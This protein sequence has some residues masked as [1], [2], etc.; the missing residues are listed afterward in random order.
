MSRRL[1]VLV[2]GG[3]GLIGA[4]V[5]RAFLLHGHDVTVLSRG[6][7]PVAAGATPLV[8]DR[9]DPVS[10]AGVLAGRRYDFVADLLAYD[11]ADVARLL[12]VPGFRCPRYALVS[13]GQ[14]YLVSEQRRPPFREGDAALPVAPE[15]EAGT[16]DHGNWLYGVGKREAERAALELGRSRGIATT[17]LRLPVVQGANDGSR[18]LWGY[19]QRLLDGGPLLLPEGG[20]HPVRF[21]WAEDVGRAFVV[22]AERPGTGEPAYNLAQPDEPTL[23]EFLER[24]AAVAGI[25]PRF[26]PCEWSALA[27]AGLDHAVSPYSGR[28]CS[29]PDPAL[30]AR[31]LGFE[32]TASDA[33]LPEVVAAHLAEA[34]PESHPGYAR[35]ALELA[36]ARTIGANGAGPHATS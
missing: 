22:L 35:R 32:A 25:P 21:V 27:G 14:V 28:W 23:R 29:R 16:R 8:A 10:L 33:W 12:D 7:R 20:D 18:R 11:R 26:V 19:L 6:G 9:R 2:V 15:P 5:A 24:A 1:H 13:S 17:A 31:D 30:A 36:L 4:P 3:S 34:S